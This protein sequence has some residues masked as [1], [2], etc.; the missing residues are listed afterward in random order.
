MNTKSFIFDFETLGNAPYGKVIDLACLVIDLNQVENPPSFRE[1][2]KKAK[3]WKFDIKS[4]VNREADQKVIE[5]WKK[6]SEAAK[7]ILVN[8]GSEVLVEDSIDDFNEYLYQNGFDRKVGYGYCRGQS[9]DFPILVDILRKKY[10]TT[11]TFEYEPCRFWNQRDIRS[12]ISG[13]LLDESKTTVPLKKGILQGFV[14]H[15]SVHDICKDAL[16]I[17]YAKRYA[18]GLEDIPV[19]DDIDPNTI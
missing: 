17:I 3:R 4:Q 13:I 19:G 18:L 12:V 2:V 8:D 15:N 5:W 10:Q 14:K 1:L 7:A 6:Q 16:M 11:D 9:F